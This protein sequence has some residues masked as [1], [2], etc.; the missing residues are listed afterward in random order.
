MRDNTAV[1]FYATE[2][3]CLKETLLLKQAATDACEAAAGLYATGC[4]TRVT[5]TA[6]DVPCL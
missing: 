5:R 4:R 1:R 3:S 2:L 6:H